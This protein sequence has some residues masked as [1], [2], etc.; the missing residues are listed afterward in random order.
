MA[1]L[2]FA[3][4]FA[5]LASL[6]PS[7]SFFWSVHVGR[8]VSRATAPPAQTVFADVDCVMRPRHPYDMKS[9]A[10]LLDVYGE[11]LE[12]AYRVRAENDDWVLLRKRQRMGG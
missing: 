11:H 5:P 6:P 12:Q 1:A 2:D 7:R 9:T 4:A 10:F 8:T 3:Q